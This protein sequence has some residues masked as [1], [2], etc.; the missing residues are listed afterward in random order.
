MCLV[1]GC[2]GWKFSNTDYLCAFHQKI[3][4]KAQRE[5]ELKLALSMTKEE[6][7]KALDNQH[8]GDYYDILV[9]GE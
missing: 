2:N 7:L 3:E 9:S 4:E 8:L 1:K 6:F 5:E